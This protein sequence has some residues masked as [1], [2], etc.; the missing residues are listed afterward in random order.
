VEFYVGKEFFMEKEFEILPHMADLK[1]RVYGKDLKELFSHALKG[2]FSSIQPQVTPG[3]GPVQRPFDVSSHDLESLLVDFLSHALYLSDVHGE[4][5]LDAK[6]EAM[7]ET[8]IRGVLTGVKI[9]DFGEGEIKAVTHHDLKIE[10]PA[11]AKAMAGTQDGSF[12]AEILFD[13]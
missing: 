10:Q 1:I 9:D 2:M 6:I 12:V 5:Y 13:I 3:S 8:N 4:A 11:V 7:S